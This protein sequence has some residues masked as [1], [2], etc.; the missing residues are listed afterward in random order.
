MPVLAQSRS[1]PS[2]SARA[3]QE[4]LHMQFHEPVRLA[5]LFSSEALNTLS[6]LCAMSHLA[7][8]HTPSRGV[9]FRAPSSAFQLPKNTKPKRPVSPIA[10]PLLPSKQYIL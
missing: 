9:I 1:P 10:T 3:E 7:C 8:L 4:Y 2:G 5:L 6:F